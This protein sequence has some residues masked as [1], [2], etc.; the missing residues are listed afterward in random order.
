MCGATKEKQ[1]KLSKNRAP[2]NSF[3]LSHTALDGTTEATTLR[4]SMRIRPFIV[5]LAALLLAG[6]GKASVVFRPGEKVKYLAP[7]EEEISGNAKQLFS[8]A[9]EAENKGDIGRAI[10]AYNHLWR[11]H[12]KDALAPGAVF[13]AA[14]L[15]EQTGDYTTAATTYRVIVERYPSSPHFDEAIEAQFRIGEMY[16]GGRN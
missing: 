3:F 14:E 15:T 2:G 8:I 4:R 1:P 6:A 5:I 9:Q 13:R 12:P 16:L 7:G 11:K 10:K